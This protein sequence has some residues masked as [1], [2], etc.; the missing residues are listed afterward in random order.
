MPDVTNILFVSDCYQ[1][2]LVNIGVNLWHEVAIFFHVCTM[3]HSVPVLMRS[4]EFF[5]MQKKMFSVMC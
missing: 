4:V 1:L 2:A 5:W 3:C